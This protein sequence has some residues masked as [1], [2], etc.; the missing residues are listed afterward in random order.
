MK[1]HLKV[2]GLLQNPLYV[3]THIGLLDHTGSFVSEMSCV[4]LSLSFRFSTRQGI[5]GKKEMKQSIAQK[6]LELESILSWMCS[7]L[8]PVSR[9][10][11]PLALGLLV[12]DHKP[13][14]TWPS[15]R[16][17]QKCILFRNSDSD[18]TLLWSVDSILTGQGI[19]QVRCCQTRGEYRHGQ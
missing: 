4:I 16:Q 12:L 18:L 17:V 9:R 19:D 6:S 1:Y 15:K 2:S 11:K 8:F 3:K 13:L 14:A 10:R 7:Y 5:R